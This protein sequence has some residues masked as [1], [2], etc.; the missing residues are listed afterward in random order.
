MLSSSCPS[1]MPRKRAWYPLIVH[2]LNFQSGT[3][4]LYPYNR[5]VIM[6]TYHYTVHT[7]SDQWMKFFGS[8]VLLCLPY[9]PTAR[10]F[11]HESEDNT[12]TLNLSF[13][14]VQVLAAAHYGSKGFLEDLCKQL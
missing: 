7:F 9:H 11:R 3:I 1:L 6:Y 14:E 5:D 8:F 12:G 13:I 2:V 10:Y 4:V